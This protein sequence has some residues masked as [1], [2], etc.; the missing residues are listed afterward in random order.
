ML[1]KFA[2]FVELRKGYQPAK[3]QCCRSSESSFTE[4][5]ENNDDDIM[6][7]FHKGFEICIAW[8]TEYILST[9]KVSY[10]SVV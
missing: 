3:F 4:G 8:K 5:L 9:C 2:Y 10:L 1:F 6:T 7:S